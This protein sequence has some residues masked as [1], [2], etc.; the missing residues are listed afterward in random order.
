MRLLSDMMESYLVGLLEDANLNAIHG[1]G[2]EVR[3]KD[4]QLAR[5]VRGERA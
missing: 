2:T 5:R 4:L 1:R 3:P